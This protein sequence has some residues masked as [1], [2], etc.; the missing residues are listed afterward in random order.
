MYGLPKVHKPDVPLRPILA[1]YNTPTYPLAKFLV[2]LLQ[3]FTFNSYT[4]QNSY[5]FYKSITEFRADNNFFMS[6][7]DI[8]SM[9]TNIPVNETIQLLCEQ[10]FHT[11][12]YFQNFS[13][14]DFKELLQLTCNESFFIFDK[15]AY[16]QR[17]GAQM[18]S[19]LGPTLANAFLCYHERNWLQNCPPDFKPIYYK[20]YVDDT[21]IFFRD[22][23]HAPKF[24]EYL[25]SQHDNINFT[26]ELENN[27]SLPFLDL[28]ITRDQNQTIQT[29]IYRKK[30]FSGLGMSFFSYT[31][32]KFKINNIK[33]LLYRAYHLSSSY[34][35]IHLEFEFLRTF[36]A[37]N[38]Y[39]AKMFEVECKKFLSNIYNPPTKLITANRKPLY[40]SLP[41][42]GPESETLYNELITKLSL[43]YPQVKFYL[44]L[45]NKSTIRTLFNFK[46]SVPLELRSDIIYEFSCVSCNATYVGSTRRR[47]KERVDQHLGRSSRTHR[48]LTNPLHST[49]RNHAELHNHPLKTEHFK[50]IEQMDNN[51]KLAI[52]ESLH[53]YKKKP[54]LNIQQTSTQ[55]FT[56]P[57]G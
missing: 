47:F 17:D 54:S 12:P 30:T 14:S 16:Q 42:Y 51:N 49:P 40:L 33:T 44:S 9:F 10:I 21:C 6:S 38:G 46:D 4:L 43:Y 11:D 32:L 35:S 15:I 2:P 45:I 26:L 25:N 27:S 28:L 41:Y 13:R 5:D 22:P 37:N 23:S 57:T 34:M 19:P 20:R 50:I 36:F 7:F 55:L 24:L 29:T 31:P 48:P 8:T 1:A 53:I 56:V 3:P 52:L 18:G 39:P